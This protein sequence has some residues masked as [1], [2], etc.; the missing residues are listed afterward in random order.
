MAAASFPAGIWD[1]GHST[2]NSMR[3]PFLEALLLRRL[4]PWSLLP[5]QEPHVGINM[6]VWCLVLQH[7]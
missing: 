1:E 7:F 3:N 4:S 5:V 6:S 2:S